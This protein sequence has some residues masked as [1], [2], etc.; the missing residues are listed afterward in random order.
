MT[1]T[2]YSLFTT[3]LLCL[4]LLPASPAAR[5]QAPGWQAAT[6]ITTSFGGFS[7]ITRTATDASGNVVVAG[8][9]QG[10]IALGS[11]TLVANGA[12]MAFVAKWNVAT[13]T[14]AWAQQLGGA[15]EA[16][17]GGLA[18]AGGS[19]YLSG[20]FMGSITAGSLSLSNPAD[21]NAFVVKLTDGGTSASWVWAQQAGGVGDDF[22]Y[23]VA[24]QGGS[25]YVVG[26]GYSPTF[27]FGAATVPT[28]AGI[29]PFVAKLTDGGATSSYAWALVPG[30]PGATMLSAVA[31][32]GSSVYVGGQLQGTRTFGTT[33]LVTSNP[34]NADA[35]VAK[36][37]DAG[38]TANWAWAQRAGGTSLERV[39]ALAASGSALYVAGNFSSSAAAF[40]A[41]TLATA[42]NRDIFVAKLLEAG[43]TT[44][45]AWAQQA[46]G[47]DE[48]DVAGLVVRGS[49]VYI[50]GQ[51]A[52]SL[53][54]FGTT[55][56]SPIGAKAGYVARLADA[57]STAAFAWAQAVGS[58][59]FSTA[60]GLALGPNR[61]YVGGYTEGFTNF[62]SVP[63]PGNLSVLYGYLA[64]I[65]DAAL[66]PTTAA[67][68]PATT[69]AVVPNPAHGPATVQL[70]AGLA[71][72][73]ATLTL[74]DAVGRPVRTTTV[75][76]AAGA[77]TAALDVAGLAPGVYALRVA[78]GERRGTA[79]LVVE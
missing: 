48:D 13:G 77:T 40:G 8:E 29:N 10:T 33:T 68:A 16:A 46:G 70:P 1:P 30:G 63:V 14:W 71:A 22:G 15:A 74:L 43:A 27:T 41:T 62:G 75:A 64:T 47:T 73:P 67:A 23:G 38:T 55:V 7:N 49:Q 39:S 60:S 6:A 18:V 72:G 57:G 53:A 36:L 2:R 24:A 20:S 54:T 51:V 59:G 52:S 21:F 9:F 37:T 17:V 65:A 78:V 25:V 19:V 56:L 3:L 44:S 69:V 76:L 28:S 61:L 5:A 32:Q 4:G 35:L 42:G 11:F 58:P 12:R 50:S 34:S 45:W 26:M 79:R 66:L 31:V